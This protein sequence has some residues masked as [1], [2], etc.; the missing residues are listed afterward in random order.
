M[1]SS[2]DIQTACRLGDV[3]LLKA[4]L[5]RSFSKLNE[6]DLKLGWTGLYR[7]VICG[8]FETTEL[9][10]KS[11]ADPNSKTKMGDTA[12][13]QA[14][15]N[16]Q[17]KLAELLLVHSADPNIQQNDGET[18]LH[19]ACFKGDLDMVK[20]LLFHKADPNI[21]NFTFGKT[22]LHYAVDYSY[23]ELITLLVSYNANADLKDK[24]G[25]S[26]KDISRS[27]E[28]STLLSRSNIFMCDPYEIPEKPSIG[29]VSP[30]LSRRN[31]E[32]S[33]YSDSKSVE[34]QVK[35]LEDIHKKI[36]EKVRGSAGKSSQNTSCNIEP[37]SE[38]S[39]TN[40]VF[41]K[42]RIISFGGTER[43]N[44]LKNFLCKFKL[45]EVTGQLIS[46]GYDD[47]NHLMFQMNSSF[48]ID[49]KS[50]KEIGIL[51]QGLRKR[52]LL[53]LDKSRSKENAC[54]THEKNYLNCCTVAV[55]SNAVFNM[56]GLA[57]WLDELS[58]GGLKENFFQAGYEELDDLVALMST[59]WEI[60]LDDLR[61]IGVD[62]P[63]YRHRILSKL[64]EDS[65]FLGVRKRDVLIEKNSNTTA[66]E[67]CI[68]F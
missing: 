42:N 15:D 19:L 68:V 23:S 36:R 24:H 14:A 44:E 57:N 64:K 37:E 29:A 41:E 67:S 49:E 2:D 51:K 35:Q 61:D 59:E 4:A 58:L 21:Q 25:K 66:C 8:H 7:S 39:A 32:L 46:A 48:P 53:A 31:S 5:S 30:I 6:K 43:S 65:M 11:G 40:V 56:P 47:L 3:L 52:L 22:A 18:P 45:E 33:I 10:L 63:G 13:H 12:L 60:T 9:L 27:Q 20:L 28:I 26:A 54:L 50:L 16:R 17:Y 34:L 38:R 55:P 1:E 62:K